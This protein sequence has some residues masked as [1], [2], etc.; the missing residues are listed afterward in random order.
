[1]CAIKGVPEM[2]GSPDARVTVVVV[3]GGYGGYA[4]AKAL[5]E[6]AD[7]TLVE[8]R[9]AFVHNVA[10]L[11]A[12]VEPD[13]LP[14][15]FLPYDRLL[16]NG[17]VVRARA[18]EVDNGRVG[19]SNGAVLTPEVIVLA[20]GSTYPY[21]AKTGTDDSAAAIDRYR[22]THAELAQASRVL[23][24]GAGPTGLEL[25]GEISYRW[26]D[27]SI[28]ILEPEHEILDGPYKQELR[29]EVRRQ[30]EARD[31]TFVLG[32]PLTGEPES[33]PGMFG[34][35]GVA[36]VSG[37]AVGADIW[38]RCHGLRPVSDYLTGELA[39]ARLPDGSIEVE[40][41]LQVKGQTTVFAIGDVAG[42]DLKTAGR[43][44]RQAEVA[45][46]N[47][48][49]LAAGETLEDYE[50]SPPAIVIPL[51]PKGGASE[52]P[53]QDEIAGPE[54]TAAIKGEHMFLDRYREQFD[55]LEPTA[56]T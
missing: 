8:P 20:T 39:A 54:P 21:P 12:L 16:S 41:T 51:G 4:V 9:D 31:V 42:I 33:P 29:D 6:V 36:T 49:A 44:G 53:G 52:L 38:F 3:G 55:L 56:A 14:S 15:I 50:P 1:M 30:L 40:S 37:R 11:R 25:A 46:A 28:T 47:V 27:T 45:A 5:D 22:H 18:V 34:A 2:N 19:L 10:A 48:R 13:W 7:V 17:R 23:I 26:P 32:D 24:V 35:F 43:A